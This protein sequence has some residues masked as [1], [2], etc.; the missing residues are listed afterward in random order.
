VE[1]SPAIAPLLA[2]RAATRVAVGLFNAPFQRIANAIG[3]FV[4]MEVMVN[5]R[6][7][8]PMMPPINSSGMNTAISEKLIE[9]R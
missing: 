2:N 6:N 9:V 8:R 7:S 1:L 5:S 3:Y 4:A